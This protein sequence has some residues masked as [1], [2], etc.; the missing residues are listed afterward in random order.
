MHILYTVLH[1]TSMRCIEQHEFYTILHVESE[2]E[3]FF[4]YNDL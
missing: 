4:L 3:K 1:T 2:T